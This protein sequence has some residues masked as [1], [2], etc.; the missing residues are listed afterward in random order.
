[1]GGWGSAWPRN[2]VRGIYLGGKGGSAPLPIRYRAGSGGRRQTELCQLGGHRSDP[3]RLSQTLKLC[4]QYVSPSTST[5]SSET[6]R[7]T[8]QPQ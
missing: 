5:S 2:D 7:R 3:L 8:S 6:P 1:M 4:L